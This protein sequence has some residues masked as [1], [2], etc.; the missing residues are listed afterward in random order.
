MVVCIL[1][2][3]ENCN[4]QFSWSHIYNSFWWAY[5]RIECGNC[6]TKHSIRISGRFIFV[7][8]T[9]L[10]MWIF[11]FFLSPFSNIFITIGVGLA[12]LLVGSLFTPY[13]VKYKKIL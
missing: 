8:L 11:G 4:K 13:V 1:Q 12:I 9:I 2:K 7:S 6:N 10:P 3:C 5:K